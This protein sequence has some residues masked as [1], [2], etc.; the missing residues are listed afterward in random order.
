MT[1]ARKAEYTVAWRKDGRDEKRPIWGEVYG[2]PPVVGVHKA[3]DG[4][5]T[6][7]HL[8]TG[9]SMRRYKKLMDAR[10][11]ARACAADSADTAWSNANLKPS[12]VE[13][14]PPAHRAQRMHLRDI[15]MEAER[16]SS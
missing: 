7:T 9:M 11:V 12:L 4:M 2:T 16:M 6:L 5:F 10:K 1:A 15:I 13:D 8:A 3:D 14:E